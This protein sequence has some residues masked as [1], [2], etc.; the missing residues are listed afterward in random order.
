MTKATQMFKPLSTEEVG[1]AEAAST[2]TAQSQPKP[3]PIVPVP[4]DAPPMQYRHRKHGEPSKAWAYHDADGQVVGYALRWDFTGK[5]GKLDK[6]FRPICYCDLDDGRRD[7]REGRKG[8]A[9][10]IGNE[11]EL[12]IG[13]HAG[14]R[15]GQ[16]FS[17][18]RDTLVRCQ[19]YDGITRIR[20]VTFDI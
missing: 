1:T 7:W 4:S 15:Y 12:E 9:V 13:C 10:I 19:E 6:E 5:D 18:S 11:V 20:C 3:V 8:E 14:Y 16:V 17:V 2:S